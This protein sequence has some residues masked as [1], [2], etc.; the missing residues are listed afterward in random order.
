LTDSAIDD[1]LKYYQKKEVD[2]T[3]TDIQQKLKAKKE[4]IIAAST[5]YDVLQHTVLLVGTDKKINL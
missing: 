5:Y 3:I 4:L 2:F 1:A